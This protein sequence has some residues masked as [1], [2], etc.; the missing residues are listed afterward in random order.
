M[1]GLP[2]VLVLDG[3][4]ESGRRRAETLRQ[5]GYDV[6]VS[7]QYEEAFR[8]IY[9]GRVRCTVIDSCV[10][11]SGYRFALKLSCMRTTDRLPNIVYLRERSV[12]D[13]AIA[14]L[15]VETGR[16]GLNLEILE[17]WATDREILQAVNKTFGIC[18]S[19]E[20]P[21]VCLD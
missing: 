21:D 12:D 5:N 6:V 16:S 7:G 20:T 13:L 9:G 3:D 10:D 4:V 18:A 11:G 15:Q 8:N 2:T 19:A 17:E 1:G 14:D